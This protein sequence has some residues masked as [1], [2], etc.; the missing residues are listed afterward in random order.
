M[1]EIIESIKKPI[2]RDKTKHFTDFTDK[3]PKPPSSSS[4]DALACSVC[5]WCVRGNY[6][7]WGC[8]YKISNEMKELYEQMTPEQKVKVNAKLRE[9]SVE[10]LDSA[11]DSYSG[12]FLMG[13]VGRTEKNKE[14]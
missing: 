12:D 11:I 10:K 9:Q 2:P 14:G 6:R 8:F 7:Y 1:D 4:M 13:K 5:R 3:Q